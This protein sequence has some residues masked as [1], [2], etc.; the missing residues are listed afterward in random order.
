MLLLKIKIVLLP[1]IVGSCLL[2]SYSPSISANELLASN[3]RI[4]RITDDQEVLYDS[5][6]Q[7]EECDACDSCHYYEDDDVDEEWYD[8][9]AGW[10]GLRE[11]SWFKDL[12]H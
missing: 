6:E 7:E 4:Y 9:T 12:E 1:A 10:P 2:V 11:D 5:D 3:E 8:D